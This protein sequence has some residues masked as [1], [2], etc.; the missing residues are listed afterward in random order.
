MVMALKSA[1]MARLDVPEEVLR[2]A[3]R[4]LDGA[5]ADGGARYAYNPLAPDTDL[6]REGRR[7]NLPM[8]AE[9]LLMR[10]YLGW[11]RNHSALNA[12][13]RY[14]LENLPADGTGTNP[15]RDLYYWYYATQVMFQLQGDAW[16]TWNGR[17]E[18][19]LVTSQA[20]TG[21]LAGSWD[22]NRPV[23]DRW[24][25]AGGRIYVTALSLLMLEAPYR[26]LPLYGEWK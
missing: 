20:K 4:W 8:T 14:L 24:A 13:A 15:T 9:G 21:P 10:M 26:H 18:S 6:E 22:P 1:Q 12:G 16:K 2:N 3:S 23:R 17:L 19:L 7:T 25:H 11:D 5:Q